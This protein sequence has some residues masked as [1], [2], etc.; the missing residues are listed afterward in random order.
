MP[1]RAQQ[2][3]A[4]EKSAVQ[5]LHVQGRVHMLVGSGANVTVQLGDQ[6]VVL[7][8]TGLPQMSPQVLA[9]IRSGDAVMIKGSFG[10]K[11]K[12][13]VTALEKRFP[14]KAAFDEAAV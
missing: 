11:M 1:A 8:D 12:T 2:D 14:G 3:Q 7:V 10:S 4:Y 6:Y 5:L 13:I 9:A